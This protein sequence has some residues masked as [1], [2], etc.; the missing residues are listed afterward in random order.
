M[1]VMTEED[2][3]RN[4]PGHPYL[5]ESGNFWGQPLKVSCSRKL[6]GFPSWGQRP[7]LDGIDGPAI[8][9]IR[10]GMILRTVARQRG[11]TPY[12]VVILASI[13]EKEAQLDSERPISSRGLCLT[14]SI[15]KSGWKPTPP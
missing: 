13:V 7:S 6:T 8:F 3:M 12:Q 9:L 4:G 1:K 10:L 11:L 14:G 15:R 5:K 2:F